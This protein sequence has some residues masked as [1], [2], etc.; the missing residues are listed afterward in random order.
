M[1]ESKRK[2][3]EFVEQESNTVETTT[4]INEVKDVVE[5]DLKLTIVVRPD[6]FVK[7]FE[8][9]DF[10]LSVAYAILNE[11]MYM[12]QRTRIII[13]IGQKQ[14]EIVTKQEFKNKIMKK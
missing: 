4:D 5:K 12:V 13:D 1:G 2:K 9:D 8:G 14:K 6:G 10:Q 7:G 3:S 11:A